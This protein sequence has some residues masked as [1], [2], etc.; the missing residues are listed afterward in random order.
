[1]NPPEEVHPQWPMYVSP[2]DIGEAGPFSECPPIIRDPIFN[3]PIQYSYNSRLQGYYM[4]RLKQI[5]GRREVAYGMFHKH[6]QSRYQVG[7][8]TLTEPQ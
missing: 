6:Y 7:L 1:M 3:F 4:H 5:E 8:S 2:K